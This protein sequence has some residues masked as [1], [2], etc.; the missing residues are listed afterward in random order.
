MQLS[1][2][3]YHMIIMVILVI[4]V[5]LL[6]VHINQMNKKEG[7]EGCILGETA[8]SNS[9]IDL[10]ALTEDQVLALKGIDKRFAANLRDNEEY[11]GKNDQGQGAE[12]W[13]VGGD[14]MVG[15]NQ[16]AGSCN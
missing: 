4:T 15:D 13:M 7:Y 1:D 8:N 16:K 2:K 10:T 9:V 14:N 5:I 6:G 3:Q 11:Y 12:S